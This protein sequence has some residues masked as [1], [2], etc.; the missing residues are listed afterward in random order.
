MR[1]F[2]LGATGGTGTHVVAQALDA[3]HRVTALARVPETLPEHAHLTILRGNVLEPGDWH[4]ALTAHDA[5]VSCL[6]SADRRRTAVY[7]QGMTGI[8]TA[9]RRGGVR[10]LACVTSASLALSPTAPLSHRLLVCC[11]VRPL[12]RHVYA[13]M[14]RMERI[15]ADSDLDWTIIRPPRLTNDAFTGT[16]RAA[17]N[18]HLPHMRSLARADLAHFLLN[19]LDD[20][21]TWRTTIE[22]S[23]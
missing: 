1:L 12:Y 10:R 23:R 6:G 7:S 20:R 22:I 11:V 4:E 19:H 5:V 9:M 14:T 8:I 13:D 2:V 3:G 21:A 18:Q 16:Y 17:A 15:V